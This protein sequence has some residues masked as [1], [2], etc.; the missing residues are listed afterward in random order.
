MRAGKTMAA[1]L[2][3]LALT[4][5]APALAAS[6]RSQALGERL[7]GEVWRLIKA[8]DTAKLGG[9]ISPAFQSLHEDGARDRKQWLELIAKLNLGDY[10]LSDFKATRNG[11]LL[12]VSYRVAVEETIGGR[13]L[14]AGQPSPRLTGFIKSRSGWKLICHVNLR[15][16]AK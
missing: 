1:V 2:A 5:A 8:G 9:M 3:V 7:V 10:A 14:P 13:R 15:P 6:S 16:L 4:W 11:A 12:L